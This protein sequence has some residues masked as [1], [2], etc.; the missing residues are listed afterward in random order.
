MTHVEALKRVLEELGGRSTLQE[1]YPRAVELISFKEGSN[2]Q[3]TLRSSL[4]RH[5]K[6]FRP[7]AG[8]PDGWWELVSFQEDIATRDHRIHELEEENARLKAVRTEDDFVRRIVKETKKLYKH[9]KEKTEVIRQILYK[10]GRSDA[11]EELDAWIEGREYKTAETV[12]SAIAD[13]T[14]TLEKGVKDGVTI[15]KAQVYNKEV[16]QQDY[17]VA[18]PFVGNQEQKRL[19]DGR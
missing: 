11:E 19:A 1:I 13:L 8:K 14:E 2:I 12:A 5:P 4:Q 16:Q 18:A 10:V 17:H 6:M 9:D 7:S 15:V 3:A